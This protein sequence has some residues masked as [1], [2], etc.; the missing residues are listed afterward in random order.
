MFFFKYKIAQFRYEFLET[1]MIG[2]SS[3]EDAYNEGNRRYSN[4][5]N[6]QRDIIIDVA[7]WRKQGITPVMKQLI[8]KVIL[9]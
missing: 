7:S 2:T 4:D 6:A 9:T 8:Q 3:F 1:T 5:F